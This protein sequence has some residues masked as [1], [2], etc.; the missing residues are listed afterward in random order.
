MVE[1]DRVTCDPLL[2]VEIEEMRALSKQTVGRAVIED[3]TEVYEDT[4]ES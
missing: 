3:F 1:K 2:S 4:E